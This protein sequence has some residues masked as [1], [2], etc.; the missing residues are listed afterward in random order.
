MTDA[1]RLFATFRYAILRV[2]GEEP[3]QAAMT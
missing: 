1:I 3:A 2:R